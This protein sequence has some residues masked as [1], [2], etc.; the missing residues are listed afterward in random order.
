MP[1]G[2]SPR[3]AY[4]QKVEDLSRENDMLK[5]TFE[6]LRT[7]DAATVRKIIKRLRAA[8]DAGHAVARIADAGLLP[9]ASAAAEQPL[10][11]PTAGHL[12]TGTSDLPGPDGVP[13]SSSRQDAGGRP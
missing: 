10:S 3:D 12:G 2:L 13:T 5:R 1:E 8:P 7:G 4:K 9:P 6:S 11:I